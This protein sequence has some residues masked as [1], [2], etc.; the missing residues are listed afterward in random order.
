MQ[1]FAAAVQAGN[2]DPAE[3]DAVAGGPDHRADVVGVQVEAAQWVADAGRIGQYRAGAGFL[4]KIQAAA[5]DVRIDHVEEGG[6]DEVATGQALGEI[7][8]DL[9]H[10]VA[11]R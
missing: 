4:R 7:G 8:G 1:R 2:V 10:P 6:V 9:D 11:G 5:P 3:I